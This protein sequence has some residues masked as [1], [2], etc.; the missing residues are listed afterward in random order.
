MIQPVLESTSRSMWISFVVMLVSVGA[1]YLTKHLAT[2][3]NEKAACIKWMIIF[4]IQGIFGVI[5]G[6][7]LNLVSTQYT[8]YGIK[9]PAVITA[10]EMDMSLTD[11]KYYFTIKYLKEDGQAVTC[12][13]ATTDKEKGSTLKVDDEIE[14]YYFTDDLQNPVFADIPNYGNG[15]LFIGIIACGIAIYLALQYKK[16]YA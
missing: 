12:Q 16:E 6:Y 13:L 15:S 10:I 9:T 1:F 4:L 14:I 3:Q 7:C 8:T 2:Y 5:V 11:M